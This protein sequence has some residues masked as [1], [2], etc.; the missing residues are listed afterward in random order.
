MSKK[1][2]A[3][4]AEIDQKFFSLTSV[5]FEIAQIAFL[6]LIFMIRLAKFT[7][8]LLIMNQ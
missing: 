2:I 5:N 6:K 7:L 8:Q 4:F 3:A 1:E